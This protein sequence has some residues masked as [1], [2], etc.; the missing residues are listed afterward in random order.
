MSYLTDFVK[1][2]N[3]HFSYGGNSVLRGMQL[4]CA[5][6]EWLGVVGLNGSGKTTL[7]R[8]LSGQLPYR[9][10]SVSLVG[11]EMNRDPSAAKSNL[12]FAVDSN[13][14]PDSLTGAQYLRLIGSVRSGGNC[15]GVVD[16]L[17][18][19]FSMKDILG[20]L[21]ASYSYG[22]RKKLG[23]LGALVGG[24]RVLIFDESLNGLDPVS[25]WRF[26]LVLKRLVSQGNCAVI[27]ATHSL[28]L[29]GGWCTRAVL[30]KDGHFE[31]DWDLNVRRAQGATA[32]SFEAEVLGR[33]GPGNPTV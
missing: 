2:S 25:G 13:D 29:V 1:V 18:E 20:N 10:G 32:C 21:I 7:L 22:T 5:S 15:H 8:I 28:E 23:I 19:A 31:R 4:T 27:L 6:G 9:L 11:V 16:E 3:L 24:P 33:S 30:L 26:K 12:G 14:L 17:T